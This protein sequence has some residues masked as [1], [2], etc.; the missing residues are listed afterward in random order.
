MGVFYANNNDFIRKDI[1]LTGGTSVTLNDKIDPQTIRQDLAGQ[2]DGIDTR[3]IYD[4]LTGEQK[5]V[6]IETKTDS[7]QTKTVLENYLGYELTDANSSFEF[8]G[9]GLSASF[10][11]QMIIA[12]FLAFVFMGMV[13]FIIFGENIL[14]KTY[15][16]ILAVLSVKIAYSSV[17]MINGLVGVILLVLIGFMFFYAIKKK[18]KLILPII[19][20][21]LML[22]FF[23]FPSLYVA[24]TLE[25]I[26]LILILL[27]GVYLKHSIPSF[28]VIIS[29]FADIF[30]TLVVV[31]MLGISLSSAGIVAFLMLIGYSVDTDILLTTRMMKRTEGKLNTRIWGAFKTG[32]TMTLTSLLAIGAALIVVNSFSEVLSQIFTI[33]VIGLVFDL[34]NTW[35]TNVSILKW[36]MEKNETIA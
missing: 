20:S 35:I 13:V 29:A 11:Q 8:T 30:M 14:V 19:F 15:V 22:F 33:L 9:S 4:L 1:S 12:I 6:I 3:G 36:Y 24:Y 17:S 32:T 21:L 18:S 34:I 23:I 7:N 2:L 31:N 25:I 5:A 27:M 26:L 10:Y 28:A 16:I